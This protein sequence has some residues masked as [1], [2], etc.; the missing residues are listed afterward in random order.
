VEIIGTGVTKAV[1]NASGMTFEPGTTVP[2]ARNLDSPGET[3][4]G[5]PP[6]GQRGARPV[7]RRSVSIGEAITLGFTADGYAWSGDMLQ[8]WEFESGSPYLAGAMRGEIE[9]VGG[10]AL[11]SPIAALSGLGA[12]SL[13]FVIG[14]GQLPT[15]QRVWDVLGE[16]LHER[17]VTAERAATAP[18]VAGE[19]LWWV[20]FDQHTESGGQTARL[21]R[22]AHDLSGA[23]QIQTVDISAELSSQAW[24]SIT[25]QGVSDSAAW[26][27]VTWNDDVNFELSGSKRIRIPLNG[28]AGAYTAEITAYLPSGPAVALPGGGL[29]VA[30]GDLGAG[31][32]AD[33]LGEEWVEL[34]P[35]GWALTGGVSVAV[36][37]DGSVALYSQ[38][39]DTRITRA[40][41]PFGGAPDSSEI[42]SGD[43]PAFA[44]GR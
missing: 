18:Q 33:T 9:I 25:W 31:F 44:F 29:G 19:Y 3:I 41:E 5:R 13:A 38:G 23:T 28:S 32:M 24:E 1:A 36:T 16:T 35:G 26:V 14:N 27:E 42:V 30:D 37:A 21:Y 12:Y 17:S 2:V 40:A 7:V 11:V 10:V 4:I 15:E 22:S 6:P 34:W 39:D 8:A 43:A 20:E